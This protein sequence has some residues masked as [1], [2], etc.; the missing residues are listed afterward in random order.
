MMAGLWFR[1]IL[2]EWRQHR[3]LMLWLVL[4]LVNAGALLSAIEVLNRAARASFAQS[5]EQTQDSRPWRIQASISGHHIPHALWLSLRR[6]GIDTEPMLEGRALLTEGDWLR[7]RN[8]GNTLLAHHNE[9]TMLTDRALAER[10][11]WVA[12]QQLQLSDGTRLPPIT[13]VEGLGPFL[14][15]DLAPLA[16]V[17]DSDDKLTYLTLPALTEVDKAHVLNL[18][19]PELSLVTQDN[20]AQKGLL[21]ALNLNLS[22]L[23]VLAF[24]VALLLAFHAFERLLLKRRRAHRVMQQLGITRREYLWVI[25]TE[26]S[27]LALLC[28][29]IGSAVGVALAKQLAPGLGDTLVNLYGM[30]SGLQVNWSVVQALEISVLLWGSMVLMGAWTLWRPQGR[31]ARWSLPLCVLVTLLLW[32]NATQAW[33][34]LLVCALTVLCILLVA[35]QLMAWV[36]RGLAALSLRLLPEQ[37]ATL[38][39]AASDQERQRQHLSLAAMAITLALAMAVSTRVMVGSFEVALVDHLNQRLFADYYIGGQEKTLRS[40]LGKLNSLPDEVYVETIGSRH[41]SVNDYPVR[42]VVHEATEQPW[43]FTHFKASTPDWWTAMGEGGCIVNEPLALQ[44]GLALDAR[45]PIQSG[46]RTLSCRLVAIQYDYGNPGGQVTMQRDLVEAGLGHVPLEGVAI[47]TPDSPDW[48]RDR[49]TELGIPDGAIRPQGALRELALTLFSRTFVITN[50]LASLTLLVGFVSWLAS[51]ASAS[52]LWRHD[53]GVLLSIGVTPG[54]LLWAR[55]WQ[56]FALLLAI[57]LI[58]MVGGQILG[59]QLLSLVN[60]LSFGWT[61]AVHPLSGGWWSYLVMALTGGLVLAIWPTYREL[62]TAPATM[63]AMES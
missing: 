57:L 45:I 56:V 21:A 12:G 10:R 49:L 15:M 39:W 43:P 58:G 29:A 37:A 50:A 61:M 36:Q 1:W 4:G 31:W 34:A 52:R 30:R 5:S 20:P 48:V 32:Q 47:T 24:A 28:G 62:K 40:W 38:L 26:W 18:L 25:L 41:G 33:Q 9:W 63:M 46:Q 19:P 23:S 27:V 14:L 35:P 53:H 13:L 6:A 22:A 51:V 44:L 3:A 60:P 17:L 55:V 16:Q 42:I 2:G 54:Q 11:G 7:L 8:A 59:Y